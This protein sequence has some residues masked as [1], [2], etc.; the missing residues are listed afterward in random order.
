MKVLLIKTGATGDVVRTTTLLHVYMYDEVYWITKK[1]NIEVLPHE[2]DC[3]KNIVAIEDKPKLDELM[4]IKFDLVLSLDDDI[5]SVVLASKIKT[6]QFIGA[7]MENDT[8]MKYT[9]D[10]AL[11]FDLSLI[12]RYSKKEAD[13]MKYEGKKSVQEYLFEMVGNKFCGQ[14]YFVREHTDAE[15]IPNLIGIEDRAGERWPTKRW[16][17]YSLLAEEL[18]K[19]GYKI[20]I[21]THRDDIRDYI[22]DIAQCSYIFTGDS[23]C[24]HFALAKKVPLVTIFTCTSAAEIYSYNRMQKVVSPYLKQAF[25]RTDYVAQAVESISVEDVIDKFIKLKQN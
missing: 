8:R 25:F 13:R 15:K 19:Q 9:E 6:N 7:Y 3:L 12:S 21:F 23:L 22:R 4:Q 17:K 2:L 5:E 11:W 14:E 24:M 16:D 10:S 20:K 1:I 18:K